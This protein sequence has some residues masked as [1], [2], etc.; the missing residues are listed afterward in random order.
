MLMVPEKQ[1]MEFCQ[2]SVFEFMNLTQI[3]CM[4]VIAMH[5]TAENDCNIL[6]ATLLHEY[7]Y[8]HDTVSFITYKNHINILLISRH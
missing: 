7:M 8:V 2:I 6:H 5:P 4:P 1:K 3:G